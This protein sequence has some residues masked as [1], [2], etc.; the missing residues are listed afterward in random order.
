LNDSDLITAII[1]GTE[2]QDNCHIPS[3]DNKNCGELLILESST[4]E[5]DFPD[6]GVQRGDRFLRMWAKPGHGLAVSEELRFEDLK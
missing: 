4:A 1:I 5:E 6:I 3:L 2:G